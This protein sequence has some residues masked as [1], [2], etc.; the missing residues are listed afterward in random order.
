MSALLAIA[1]AMATSPLRPRRT[2]VFAAW[3]GEE[4]GHFGSRH[5]M[6]HPLWPLDKTAAYLNL[7]MIAHPWTEA[8]IR[9]LVNGSGLRDGEAWMRGIRACDFV[10]AGVADWAAGAL[11]PV[12]ASAS[13]ATGLTLHIDRT[14]G[15]HGGSDYRSFALRGVPFVRFFGSYFPDYHKPGDRPERLDA[16]QI[17]RMARL[18]CATVWLLANR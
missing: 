9:T 11:A 12:L 3:T 8:E 5:Y 1:R 16:G 13:T 6:R 4:M 2:V 18:A 14:S 10:E 17:E 7:D 15:R